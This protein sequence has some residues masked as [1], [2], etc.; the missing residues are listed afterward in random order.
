MTTTQETNGNHIACDRANLRILLQGVDGRDTDLI[1]D[2]LEHCPHCRQQYDE[3]AAG[4]EDWNTARQALQSGHWDPTKDGRDERWQ[5]FVMG[6]HPSPRWTEQMARQLLSAPSHPEMLGRLGRYEVESLI[7][8]GGMGV[9][10]R[11]IDTEL[12]RQVA[13][14]LL[15]PYLAGHG[16]ARQRFAR[17]ARAAAAIVHDHVVP[18][19]D[20]EADREVPFLVMQY[21][22]G[23]SLQSR[24]DRR[25]ALELCEVLRIGMQVASGVAAA[26]QQ[27]L[28]HRDIKPSNIL[29]EPT[30][31]R[32]YITD[33]GLARAVDDASLTYSGFLAGTPQYMSP[34]QAAGESIDIRSDLF[35]LGSV[36]Y[37]AC[38][39]RPPFRAESSLG[40]L[41]RIADEEPRPIQEIN[42][43]VPAWLGRLISRLMAKNPPDRFGSAE[44]VADL[45]EQCLAHVQQPSARILPQVLMPPGWFSDR[46]ARRVLPWMGGLG[47]FALLCFAMAII[48]LRMGEGTVRIESN[49]NSP[50]AVRIR[51]GEETVEELTIERGSSSIRL[52]AGQYAIEVE[53][54]KADV[55]ILGDQITLTRGETWIA[56]IH[57][58][59]RQERKAESSFR[60]ASAEETTPEQ[61][62]SAAGPEAAIDP[63]GENSSSNSVAAAVEAFNQQHLEEMTTAGCSPVTE[64]EIISYLQW[65]IEQKLMDKRV[66]PTLQ[67][68]ILARRLPENWTL[69]GGLRTYQ[70]YNEGLTVFD[71]ELKD[72]STKRACLIRRQ[73]IAPPSSMLQ[74]SEPADHPNGRSLTDAI[75]EFNASHAKFRGEEMVPLKLNEVLA[76]IADWKSRRIEADVDEATFQ[77]FQ[78]IGR[79][80]Q[81]PE[82]AQLEVI[83]TFETGESQIYSVWT[84]RIVIPQV[85]KPGWTYAFTIREQFLGMERVNADYI[86]W[87]TPGSNGLQAG[88]RL[89]PA[90]R[91]YLDGQEVSVEFF[92]RSTSGKPIPAHLPESFRHDSLVWI[93]DGYRA[94][95][96][97]KNTA[98]NFEGVQL[99]RELITEQGISFSGRHIVMRIRSQPSRQSETFTDSSRPAKM[100]STISP[101]TDD[102]SARIYFVVPN[103]GVEQF[104]FLHTGETTVEVTSDETKLQGST[105]GD[106]LG[107]D[108]FDSTGIL[109][110]ESRDNFD[111]SSPPDVAAA[112]SRLPVDPASTVANGN[113]LAR[114]QGEWDV[115]RYSDEGRESLSHFADGK[116]TL[117][118]RGTLLSI[119]G[120][121]AEKS[122]P[123]EI[124]MALR[125]R[126]AEPIQ[127]VDVLYDPNS[128][129][130]KPC[131]LKGI[132]ELE[133]DLLR[134][135]ISADGGATDAQRPKYFTGGSNIW[136]I[137]ARRRK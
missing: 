60:R 72:L 118:I 44:E 54:E 23:E 56:R 113:M 103:F 136:F 37:T 107:N 64:D 66:V 106:R 121:T 125:F 50:V 129:D 93:Q 74:P 127:E 5:S 1:E 62:A 110:L 24:I 90:Q 7:G 119:L 9:V 116:A 102:I 114:L 79:T 98:L 48:V 42:P 41:R 30:V 76:A 112:A 17:E 124:P 126:Q 16:L 100:P 99:Q 89:R 22:G 111:D 108:R 77:R 68:M 86:H 8:S 43:E 109:M 70:A 4:S 47:A 11:A 117:R 45:L 135:C 33:F 10:F 133:D 25:G 31:D 87:G 80:H 123:I 19:Y 69:T 81:L 96:T 27:G 61:E 18:I 49:S 92:Y 36:L 6:E 51:Q 130:D 28:V 71:V 15:A 65:K 26:H 29:L 32:A 104:G 14:K 39:G 58:M 83:P 52:R 2:H 134:L 97:S 38:T 122:E 75:A 82:A 131:W 35:S 55:V 115:L 21:I 13:I 105:D 85:E 73:M 95:I 63:A 128:A 12:H 34:E 78:R 67:Q 57:V 88:F 94:T 84:V 91:Y 3:M 137:E 120:N 46:S 53:D 101:S 40:L 20:V 59:G 132:V